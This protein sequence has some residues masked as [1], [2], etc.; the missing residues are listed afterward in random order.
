MCSIAFSFK[1]FSRSDVIVIVALTEAKKVHEKNVRNHI[2][3]L[4]CFPLLLLVEAPRLNVADVV[5]ASELIVGAK[6]VVTLNGIGISLGC[7]L[8]R[9][10]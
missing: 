9:G 8:S 4:L 5:A 2:N 1:L 3:F 10:I 7:W 6:T